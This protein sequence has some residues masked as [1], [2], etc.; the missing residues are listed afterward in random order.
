AGTPSTPEQYS[1][2]ITATQSAFASGTRAYTVNINSAPTVSN[3]TVTE[4]TKGQSG[5]TGTMTVNNG[6]TPHTLSA[7]SGL[8]T[9]LTAVLSGTTISFTGT[10]TATGTFASGSVTI[11]D[12]AGAQA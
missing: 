8:P 5:F 11:T 2:S 3:L 10:P 12:A 4:W 7:Q 1:F 9:G 6:T